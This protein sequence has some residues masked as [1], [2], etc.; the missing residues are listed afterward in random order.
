MVSN[1]MVVYDENRVRK[2][3]VVVLS[4]SLENYCGAVNGKRIGEFCEN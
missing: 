2:T 4:M 3:L 1:Q